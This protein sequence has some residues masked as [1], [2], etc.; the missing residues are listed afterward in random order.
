MDRSNYLVEL[1]DRHYLIELRTG[2]D[3]GN[4]EQV[5]AQMRVQP[6]ML[7]R[8][9]SLQH[10]VQIQ[11]FNRLLQVRERRR[12]EQ[13]RVVGLRDH[14]QELH[15]EVERLSHAE[16]QQTGLLLEQRGN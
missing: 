3:L 12:P 9:Q 8:P 14:Y 13:L 11:H 2:H 16:I 10:P 6:R 5:Q 15:R 4:L 7:H 1:L